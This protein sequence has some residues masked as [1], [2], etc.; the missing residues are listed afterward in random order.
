MSSRDEVLQELYREANAGDQDA[1]DMYVQG[2]ILAGRGEEIPLG[3][4]DRARIDHA[5]KRPAIEALGELFRRSP[6]LQRAAFRQLFD[7]T[8]VLADSVIVQAESHWEASGADLTGAE[9]LDPEQR[10]RFV[11]LARAWLGLLLARDLLEA[12]GDS[13]TIERVVENY[14]DELTPHHPTDEVVELLLA[15]MHG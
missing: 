7:L 11:T 12:Q 9:A 3:M 14:Q 5:Y 10:L 13:E 15:A 6:A 8:F 1:L 2:M 4:F